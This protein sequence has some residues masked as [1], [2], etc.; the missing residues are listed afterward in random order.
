LKE[1]AVTHDVAFLRAIH[2]APEDDTPRLVD[3]DWLEE[4]GGPAR[5]PHVSQEAAPRGGEQ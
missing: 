4:H 5:F 1:Q 3:A 2:E